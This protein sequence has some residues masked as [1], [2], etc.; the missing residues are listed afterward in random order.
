MAPT[1]FSISPRL[2]ARHGLSLDRLCALA[3]I[4]P[5]AA[6]STDDFFRLWTAAGQA[7]GDPAAGLRLGAQGISSGDGVAAIVALHAPDFRSALAALARYKRLTCPELVEL[8]VAGAEASVAYRW[9]L[10]TSEVPRLLVD[11]TLASLHALARQGTAGRVTPLRVQ[12]AR[13]PAHQALLQD[14]FGCPIVFDAPHDAMVFARES[15]DEPFVTAGGSAFADVL[16]GLEARLAQG[17]G[18]PEILGEVRLAIARQL[19][20]GRPASADGVARRLCTSRRTLQ[21]RLSE[22][23]TTFQAQLA[24]VRR[25]TAGRLLANTDLDPVAISMLL[26]FV[27]PNSFSRAFRAWENTSPLRWRER[28]ANIKEVHA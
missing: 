20:E 8:Q 1:T 26:G 28:Q 27:E 12:L 15:L 3:G 4:A 25:T 10:A 21:R 18:S 14:H 22:S 6:W 13:R 24:G 19:S 7:L 5:A 17:E 11:T 2:V 23:R 9:L 16:D